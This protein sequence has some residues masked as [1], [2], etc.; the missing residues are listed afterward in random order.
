MLNDVVN[1]WP[2]AKVNERLRTV[3]GEG[4]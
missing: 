1:D 2:T 4:T 3:K